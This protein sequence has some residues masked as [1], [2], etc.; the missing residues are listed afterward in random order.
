[1]NEKLDLIGIKTNSGLYISDKKVNSYGCKVIEKKFFDGELAKKTFHKDWYFVESLVI[2]EKLVSHPSIN[3]RYELIDPSLESNKIPFMLERDEVSSI[4]DYERTFKEEYAHLESLYKL[5][6]DEISDTMEEVEFKLEI[7]CELDIE[8][9]KEPPG[10][11]YFVTAK[12]QVIDEILFPNI[13]LHTRPCSL[14]S[15]QMYDITRS[16]IK[17]NIDSKTAEITSDFNFC[18]TVKKKIGLSNSYENK[19]E[20]KNSKGRSYKKRRFRS[21]FVTNRTVDCFEMTYSPENYRNYTPIKGIFGD[22]K[23][24]IINKVDTYLKELITTINEPLVECP[25]CNGMGVV[26]IK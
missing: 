26:G 18:F 5:E 12:N 9:I 10:T 20:I 25:H 7:I 15:R 2:I 3:H 17:D 8:K 22:S 1:M 11:K 4:Y 24:D 21:N 13:L 6:C 19:I 23:E 16:Y 14:S